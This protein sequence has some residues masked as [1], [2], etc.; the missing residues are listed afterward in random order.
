[1]VLKASPRRRQ[2]VQAVNF[3]RRPQRLAKISERGRKEKKNEL[4]KAKQLPHNPSQLDFVLVALAEREDKVG[5]G[6]N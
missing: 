4:Q 3:S 6:R 2:G 1:M 5:D